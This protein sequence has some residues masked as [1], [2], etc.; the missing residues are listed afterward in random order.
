MPRPVAMEAPAPRA[1]RAACSLAPALSRPG[2]SSAVLTRRRS[3][4]EGAPERTRPFRR[5][6]GFAEMRG[7]KATPPIGG[8]RTPDGRPKAS[9]APAPSPW[10]ERRHCFFATSHRPATPPPAPTTTAAC[11]Q[12]FHAFLG[13]SAWQI[14]PEP[15]GHASRAVGVDLITFKLRHALYEMDALASHR[16]GGRG[17]TVGLQH[18]RP[19]DR[20]A[21][22]V[23]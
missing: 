22:N 12:G 23:V 3:G 14:I 9:L 16:E 18:I 21:H 11:R 5:F 7:A 2:R 17:V 10:E 13:K 8:G 20:E 19:D 15:A 6:A 1:R 4:W